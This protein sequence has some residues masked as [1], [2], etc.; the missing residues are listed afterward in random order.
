MDLALRDR[1]VLVVGASSG[2][3]AATARIL[4][5]EGA[6]LSLVGRRADAL[7]KLVET[8]MSEGGH[9]PL[10]LALDAGA[11]GA[12]DEAVALTVRGGAGNSHTGISGHT[13][14]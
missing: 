2:I 4:A 14:T 13:A 8:L 10:T 5:A 11:D 9:Q 12:M 6:R 1:V 7:A 3:G